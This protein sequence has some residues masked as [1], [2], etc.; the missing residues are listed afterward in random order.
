MATRNR[1]LRLIRTAAARSL[2]DRL[3]PRTLL[4]SIAGTVFNDVD[5]DGVIDAGEAGAAGFTVWADTNNNGQIDGGFA[6]TTVG[7]VIND[8]TT[9][10]SPLTIAGQSLSITDVNVSV[11]IVH[12]YNGD[13]VVTLIAPNGTRFTLVNRLGGSADGMNLTFD[14]QAAQGVSAMPTSSALGVQ[15]IGSYRPAVS[16][17]A[18]NGT[19]PNG[20][21][22]L[23]VSDVATGD[24]GSIAGWSISFNN[25]SEISSSTSTNGAYL[26]D[27]PAAGAYTV[28]IAPRSG[29]EFHRTNAAVNVATNTTNVTGVH[30]GTRLPPATITGVVFADHNNNGNQDA[31]EPGIP[32]R[33]V[34][35][36][37]DNDSALDAGETFVTTDA[38]G[39]YSL[40]NVV[41]G[42]RLVRTVLPTL[43]SQTSPTVNGS[44]APLSAPTGLSVSNAAKD[45]SVQDLPEMGFIPGQVIVS[46]SD[47]L[48]FDAALAKLAN[49]SLRNQLQLRSANE[50]TRTRS[51]SV[52]HVPVAG[53]VD[54]E[55]FA[56]QLSNLAGVQWAS[57]N[58]VYRDA[59]DPREYTPNDP[60][61]ASQYHHT[62]M[63]NNLAWDVTEGAGVRVAFTD[64]GMQTNHPDLAP[65]LW[66]NPGEI[67]GNNIDD[68]ANGYVDDVNGWDFTNSTTTGTG[69]NN[70][71]PVVATD[72]HGTHVGGII[73]A[74]TNNAVGISGTA[75]RSSLV[76]LRFYGTGNWTS[77]VIFNTFKYAADNGIKIVSTSY[78]V[79]GFAND[80]LYRTAID[81]LYNN[82]V[83]HLNSAGNG[84]AANPARQV[85]DGS[86]YVASTDTADVKS[87]FSNWGTGIDIAA[88]GSSILSTV[89]NS[90]YASYGGTSMATPNAAAVAALIWAR[91]PTW[92]RDQVA[93]QLLGTADNTDTI[94][95]NATWAGLMGTGRVNS[96][97]GV[98][99]TL[100]APRV[101]GVVGLISGTTSPT[102]FS[103]R[104]RNVLNASAATSP[105]N[106]R[107]IG[108]GDDDLFGT[109]DDLSSTINL[110]TTTYRVGTNQLNFTIPGALSQGRWRFLA[111]SGASNLRD[112]FGTPLDGNNDGTPGDDFTHDF[113]LAGTTVAHTVAAAAGTTYASRSFG[114]RERVAPR[115]SSAS[116]EFL[117]GQELVFNLT[118]DLRS[119]PLAALTLTNTTTSAVIPT[120]SYTVAFDSATDRLVFNL[121]TPLP[122]GNYT[123]TL[124]HQ[125][126]L[127]LFGNRLD[128]DALTTTTASDY[129]FNLWFKN[130]DFNRDRTV[131]FADLLTLAQNYDSTGR[132]FSQGDANYDGTVNFGDLLIIAQ[133]YETTLATVLAQR[134][135]SARKPRAINEVM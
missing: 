110:T 106:Y 94:A 102:S 107:L 86:L 122:D 100:A 56:Q 26:L 108:A 28:R 128:G 50:M 95:A 97:R 41:P 77:T 9:V 25:L 27:V 37:A 70:P 52:L 83:L 72:D 21:W 134:S 32:G 60:Q 55:K 114:T 4:A 105:T 112:P 30:F 103:L 19:S 132:N 135:S 59:S 3:E 123:A 1:S 8:N 85:I 45:Q 18:L 29:F 121:L 117:S 130:G 111:L 2:F 7:Q 133:N 57:P 68:D 42:Q 16:L 127:D 6:A 101:R 15:T 119:V 44:L 5:L 109:A 76:P 82:G 96:F 93:A 17:T 35:V 13:L 87:S 12:S 14:D 92:T 69:D 90:G 115:V 58:R 65:N 126:V 88:P 39:A 31:G 79:D 75:G 129:S 67:A 81:Y 124:N 24:T 48:R 34:Y 113:T 22:Q 11:N 98:T 74:R 54:V 64:D 51:A 118:E 120:T 62:R 104:L 73:G 53:G 84:S 36:D 47:R 91:N 20:T 131:N 49:R 78:N 71:N 38:A 63:Q 40:V 23:E 116:F 66:I 80:N 46:V 89:T 33:T 99:E 125:Q 10:T 43:W 61:Y